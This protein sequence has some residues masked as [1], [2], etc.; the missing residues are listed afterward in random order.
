MKNRE[1]CFSNID[2]DTCACVGL[3]NTKKLFDKNIN[4]IFIKL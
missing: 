3:K 4:L 1:Q 2:S